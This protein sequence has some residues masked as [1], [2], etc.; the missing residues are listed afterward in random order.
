MVHANNDVFIDLN[1]TS[2][3]SMYFY[4]QICDLSRKKDTILLKLSFKINVFKIRGVNFA[5]VNHCLSIFYASYILVDS[6]AALIIVV[7]V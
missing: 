2:Y 3:N 6:T 5:S 1:S 4:V 7:W